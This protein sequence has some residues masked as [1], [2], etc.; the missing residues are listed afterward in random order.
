MTLMY[1]IRADSFLDEVTAMT[2]HALTN[3]RPVAPPLLEQLRITSRARGDPLDTADK[4]VD[5]ARK[6]IL[7]HNKR[8]PAE[9]GL[10]AVT[11]FL[12]HV[13]RGL[14]C[15]RLPRCRRRRITEP[16]RRLGRSR[17]HSYECIREEFDRGLDS[18]RMFPAEAASPSGSSSPLCLA[19]PW[20]GEVSGTPRFVS[21]SP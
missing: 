7:F 17:V 1:T 3:A 2:P 5:W 11:Q 9:L 19:C 20:H 14:S 12:E 8:H 21:A 4:L 16:M 6:Y 15:P 18:A 13:A 10:A